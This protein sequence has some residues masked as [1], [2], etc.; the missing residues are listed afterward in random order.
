MALSIK[1]PETDLLVRR[2]AQRERIS[3]TS[4]IRLAVNNEL[5]SGAKISEKE[6]ARRRE[7]MR[8]IQ[9][10]FAKFPID[11]SLTK[12]EIL[13]YDEFGVPELPQS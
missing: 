12:E 4:A 9:R 8:D 5:K 1:D 11:Y 2:L 6:M 7:A 13:G 3:M 10:E